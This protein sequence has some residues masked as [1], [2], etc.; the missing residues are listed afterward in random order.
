[1][2]ATLDTGR[3]WYVCLPS[4]LLKNAWERCW[5]QEQLYGS[6]Y[7]TCK[8]QPT[9]CF[10]MFGMLMGRWDYVW[11]EGQC[12]LP[13]ILSHKAIGTYCIELFW[14][15][16]VSVREVW[17]HKTSKERT[18]MWHTNTNTMRGGK[19]LPDLS[20]ESC[21]MLDSRRKL[22]QVKLLVCMIWIIIMATLVGKVLLCVPEVTSRV[23]Q[24]LRFLAVH[25]VVSNL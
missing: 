20:T 18:V 4:H 12:S 1:M 21:T 7:Y 15:H 14:A 6:I 17:A 13:E 22:K 23:E 25:T 2:H 10:R 8:Q 24:V 16:K 5:K 11:A 19:S 9:L 3:V